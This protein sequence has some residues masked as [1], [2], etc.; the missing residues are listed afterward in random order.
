MKTLNEK[1]EYIVTFVPLDGSTVIEA[2][3]SVASL[4][5]IWNKDS[6]DNL[7]G[8]DLVGAAMSIYGSRTSVLAPNVNTN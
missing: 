2:N 8:R 1:G 7:S 5:S 6:L 3:Y 4:F